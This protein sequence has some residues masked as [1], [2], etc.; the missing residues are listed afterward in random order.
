MKERKWLS[1]RSGYLK[2]ALEQEDPLLYTCARVEEVV[3]HIYVW[4]TMLI[5]LGGSDKSL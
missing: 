1:F 4:I 5:S 3:L 2:R